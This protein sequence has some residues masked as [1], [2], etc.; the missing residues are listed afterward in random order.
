MEV[1]MESHAS[2]FAQVI[3]VVLVTLSLVSV[4]CGGGKSAPSPT[5]TQVKPGQLSASP[6]SIAFGSV[7]LNTTTK[8]NVQLSNPGPSSITVS[9]ASFSGPG[10]GV[11]GLGLPLTLASG[12]NL[13]FSVTFDPSS[14]GAATGRVQI[15]ASGAT[16]P[17]TIALTGTGTTVPPSSSH[18]V[19]LSW[20]PSTSTVVGYNVYRANQSGGP[21]ALTNSSLVAGTTFSDSG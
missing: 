3:T 15:M 21:Y 2:R 8:Q 19:A 16:S 20:N 14:A 17:L 12:E 18:G 4:G 9:S 10:F 5:T 6:A 13:T 1:Q 7:S 11:T